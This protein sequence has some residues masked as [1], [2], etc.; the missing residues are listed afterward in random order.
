M[1]ERTIRNL[2][3]TSGVIPTHGV[4]LQDGHWLVA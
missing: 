2:Q 1:I 3:S 4:G